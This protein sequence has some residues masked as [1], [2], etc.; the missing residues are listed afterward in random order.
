M[1]LKS[2]HYITHYSSAASLGVI[3]EEDLISLLSFSYEG[4]KKMLMNISEKLILYRTFHMP[5]QI[6]GSYGLV[7][8][9]NRK[10]KS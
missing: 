9:T 8:P 10:Y 5:T 4:S 1:L 6:R 3:K 2:E 7:K